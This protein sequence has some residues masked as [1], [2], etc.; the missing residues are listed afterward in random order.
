MRNKEIFQN[1]VTRLESM[2]NSIGRAVSLNDRQQAFD[3]I[4]RAKVMLG[5]LQTMLNRESTTFK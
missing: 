1:K 2:M 4:E 5:D 3:D